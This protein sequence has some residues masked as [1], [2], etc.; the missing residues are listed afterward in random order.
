[1]SSANPTTRLE[2][3]IA[4]ELKAT[5][6]RAAAALGLTL[7]DYSISRLVENAR[8]DLKQCESVVLSDRDRDLFLT[9]LSDDGQPNE[10]MKRAAG[11]YLLNQK[12]GLS[13]FFVATTPPDHRVMGYYCISAGSVFF[14]N[15]SEDLRKGLPRYPIPVCLIGRMAVDMVAQGRGLGET[16]LFDAFERIVRVADEVGIHAVEVQA[17]D[18]DAKNFYLK[19]GFVELADDKLHLYMPIRK[20]KKLGLV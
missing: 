9:L 8:A 17:K 3:R 19:Y 13:Q 5:I 18:A 12:L 15:I 7:T 6:E 11:R 1:M 16:L 10:A 20:I 2:V 4:P 14:Q